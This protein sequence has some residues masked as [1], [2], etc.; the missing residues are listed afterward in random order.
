MVGGSTNETWLGSLVPGPS[1]RVVAPLPGGLTEVPER[2]GPYVVEELVGRGGMATVYRCRDEA[3]EVVAVKW[4]HMPS[5]ALQ[6]RFELEIRSLAS[7]HHDSVVRWLGQGSYDGR[8]YLVMEYLEGDDLRLW[9]HRAQ[10]LPAVERRRRVRALAARLCEAL[11]YLHQAGLVHRDVKPSNVL[12]LD[13]DLPVLTDFGVV[14]DLADDGATAMG[15]V[16]GTLNY[17]SPEQLRG[18]PV[19]ARTDLYGLGCT[20]YY[21]LTGHVPF[22][23]AEQAEIVLAHLT[24]A[25]EPPSHHD[26]TIPADLEQVVLRLMAKDPAERYASASEVAAALSATPTPAGV[27]L[28][29][30]KRAL[31]RIAEALDRVACGRGCV[32]KISGRP[33]TGK[34][35]ATNTLQEGAARRGLPFLEPHE[36]AALE[37]AME[38]LASGEVLLVVT[39]L[40]EAQ[41]D[42]HVRLEPLRR[43]DLRRSVV[44]AAPG[45]QDPAALAERLYRATGGL[46]VLLLPL[47]ERLAGDAAA[48]DGPLPDIPVDPWLDA[49]DLD[50]LELLQ[51]VAVA[52]GPLSAAELEAITQVPAD[53]PLRYLLEAGLLV[54]TS[55]G[56]GAAGVG[57]STGHYGQRYGVAAEA[58]GVGAL[59]RAPDVDALRERALRV[60]GPR[61]EGG[62]F[63]ALPGLGRVHELLLAGDLVAAERE[64]GILEAAG[65]VEASHTGLL[66]ARARL[67][68]LAGR[69]TAAHA[70]FSQAA[71]RAPDGGRGHITAMLGLGVLEQQLGHSRQALELLEAAS[72]SA[73]SAGELDLEAMAAVQLTWS[74]AL[75]GRPGPALKR[76][77]ELAGVARA[78]GQPMLECVAMEVQ[79]RLLLEVGM[80]DDAARV[81]ADIS[82]LAHAAGL[83]RERW[84]AHVL[85]ARATLDHDPSSPT[86]AAAATDRLLRVLGEPPAPDPLN[87]SALAHALLAR[88]A[89]RLGDGR[90][91]RM[92]RERAMAGLGQGCSPI[93][94]IA[95]LQLARGSW[96]SG[97][98]TQARATIAEVERQAGELGYGFLAWQA[99]KLDAA[100]RGTEPEDPSGMLEGMEPTWAAALSRE[101]EPS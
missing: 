65:E 76:C 1:P 4:L 40:P 101:T 32:V 94:L 34:S 68:W 53:E 78:L 60:V 41:A 85:R 91:C 50:S 27:P 23:Q 28:A 56:H 67:D 11:E 3:G 71:Q 82:A 38:R 89:A 86:A 31:A 95:R 54:A 24:R 21:M 14:K 17:A 90:T 10:R 13:H 9:T 66:L 6:Q 46:P 7:L 55:T 77:R 58:F 100:M 87:F 62:G 59:A 5:P 80:P 88:A 48:L 45:V 57:P 99:R 36:P 49:L 26:P 44:A 16:V 37:A 15:V 8:P 52:R 22:E 42:I 93:T 43:A 33:G 51:A 73:H 92:A 18:D 70:A 25:P 47:L 29:G 39:E 83:A 98:A 35:W 69:T 97:D 72:S 96:V 30:R 19:D 2:I 20:I 64:M 75:A 63:V 12:V 61:A 81:L 74:R 84:Q 79:G